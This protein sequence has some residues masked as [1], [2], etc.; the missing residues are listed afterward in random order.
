[1]EWTPTGVVNFKSCE[2][3]VESKAQLRTSLAAQ[4]IDAVKIDSF[5]ASL[6]K[7]ISEYHGMIEIISKCKPADIRGNLKAV[8]NQIG[9]LR[10]KLNALDHNSRILINNL[11]N[12]GMSGVFNELFDIQKIINDALIAAT[13]YPKRGQLVA[14]HKRH[15]VDSIADLIESNLE[16]NPT[17][18]KEG[19][20]EQ[21]AAIVL[22]DITG[23]PTT[24]IH[25][26]V[27]K[28]I[29]SRK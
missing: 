14:Y 16:V 10:E 3:K 11:S 17:S 8:L 19:L 7:S 18:T 2:L 21:C 26:L 9:K 28:V 24:G 5:L 13:S 23:R 22:A 20:L 27:E 4:G 25:T 15:L 1:M 12:E 6:E 29:K